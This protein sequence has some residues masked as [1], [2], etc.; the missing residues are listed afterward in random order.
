MERVLK[1]GILIILKKEYL[2]LKPLKK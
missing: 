1:S 2:S